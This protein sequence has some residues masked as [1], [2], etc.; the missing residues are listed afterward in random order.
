[1]VLD[2]TKV[3]SATGIA[4]KKAEKS[5]YAKK[6]TDAWPLPHKAKCKGNGNGCIDGKKEKQ[7]KLRNSLH[8]RLV[9]QPWTSFSLP[10]HQHSM[11]LSRC[12]AS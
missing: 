4:N 7:Q 2:M 6:V 9:A 8:K 5:V 1:M 11:P 3:R 10:K 12:T